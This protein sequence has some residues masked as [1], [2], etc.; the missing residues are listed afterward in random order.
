MGNKLRGLF[1]SLLVDPVHPFVIP[2]VTQVVRSFEAHPEVPE[3]MVLDEL[4]QRI[5]SV[6]ISG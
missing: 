4:L 3:S 6:S 1:L 2:L 5:N